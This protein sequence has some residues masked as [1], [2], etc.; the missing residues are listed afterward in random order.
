MKQLDTLE[1]NIASQPFRRERAEMTG[2]IAACALLIVSMLALGALILHSRAEVADLR[3]RIAADSAK[4]SALQAQQGRF[5]AVLSKPDNTEVFSNSVFLNQLI[6]RRGLSWSRIFKDL[7]EV[8]P[9]SI[10]LLAIRLP[11]VAEQDADGVNRVQLDMVV[12]T[13]Q[14]EQF[15]ILLK[16]LEEA[17]N[18]G[19]TS[20]VS[21]T[22][23]SQTGNDPYYKY[24]L[25]VAYAQKL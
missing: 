3:T 23:P 9:S 5:G 17:N 4:L 20:V 11:Q 21:S 14:P 18:F 25:T 8:L 10:R 7:E 24:R 2:V 19:A 1:L 6:A 13:T 15:L 12:G 22:P 16:H